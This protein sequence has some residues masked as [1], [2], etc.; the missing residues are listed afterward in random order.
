VLRQED[1][2]LLLM[3]IHEHVVSPGEQ[4]PSVTNVECVG[5]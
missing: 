1:T 3:N 5:F 2:S 4:G